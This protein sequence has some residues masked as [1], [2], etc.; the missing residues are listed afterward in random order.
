[1]L[2]EHPDACSLSVVNMS[3]S[4]VSQGPNSLPKLQKKWGGTGILKLKKKC[5]CSKIIDHADSIIV[6]LAVLVLIKDM[7]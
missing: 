2:L 1:M 7:K 5:K 3:Q 6:V 4:N